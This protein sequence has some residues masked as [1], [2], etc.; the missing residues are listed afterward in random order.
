MP[1]GTTALAIVINYILDLHQYSGR[2]PQPLA[3][4]AD[5]R[6]YPWKTGLVLTTNAQT[7]NNR[8]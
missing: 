2:N 6:T 3:A 4:G 8:K 1:T 5:A 7:D